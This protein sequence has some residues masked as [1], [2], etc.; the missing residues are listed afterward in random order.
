MANVSTP[1]F[2]EV[3]Q[4]VTPECINKGDMTLVR[5]IKALQDY[6]EKIEDLLTQSQNDVKEFLQNVKDIKS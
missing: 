2:N 1:L 3:I 5:K 4:L 6:T